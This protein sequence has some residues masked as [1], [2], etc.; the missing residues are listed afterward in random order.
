MP[1]R[2]FRNV[3]R[4]F[5]L[6]DGFSAPSEKAPN[7]SVVLRGGRE[8][9]V[10]LLN[11]P[12]LL[13]MR[14]CMAADVSAQVLSDHRFPHS[15]GIMHEI[16]IGEIDE[17]DGWAL[18]VQVG[19]IAQ[20]EAPEAKEFARLVLYGG[21]AADVAKVSSNSE[22]RSLSATIDALLEVVRANTA[23]EPL[24]LYALRCA[25]AEREEGRAVLSVWDAH[26]LN[27]AT[28][29]ARGVTGGRP[30]L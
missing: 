23:F 8:I 9:D 10:G 30:R 19:P 24:R 11:S 16:V 26:G 28:A 1:K 27:H 6:D 25:L 5:D 4:A 14:L 7:T 20:D 18:M 15:G 12:E 29:P 22:A 17:V 13:S 21:S 3:A 2:S